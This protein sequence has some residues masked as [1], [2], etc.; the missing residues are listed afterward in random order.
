[1]ASLQETLDTFINYLRENKR[2][3]ATIVAYKKDIEQLIHFLKEQGTENPEQVTAESLNAF[4]QQ[5]ATEGYTSKSISRKTNSTKTFFRFLK[6]QNIIKE[7]PAVMLQHPKY[8]Q[9]PPRILTPMEYRAL[10][11]A[12]RNDVRIS[13]I[14]EILLQTGIR[15][16]ELANIRLGD[17][18]FSNNGKVSE[19]YIAPQEGREGRT[20]PMNKAAEAAVKRYL[21][22]RPQSTSDHLFLTKNGR[23]LLIRNIRTAI[24]RYFKLAGIDN[25]KV[26]DLRHTWVAHHLASGVSL[27]TIAKLAGHKRLSTTEKYLNYIKPSNENNKTLTEL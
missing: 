23:P 9:K 24:E 17:I 18:S 12:A 16:S 25:A 26:N 6:E 5:F 27:L 15:I 8:E 21:E 11:D 2:A 10:R 4:M 7:D 13:A 19:L 22:I 3:S 1:M 14:V 20:I